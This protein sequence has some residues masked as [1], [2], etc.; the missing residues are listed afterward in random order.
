MR[1]DLCFFGLKLSPFQVFELELEDVTGLLFCK[2][3]PGDL[4]N[5]HS[6]HECLQFKVLAVESMEVLNAPRI[7][8]VRNGE[9]Y[10]NSAACDVG[11]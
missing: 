3:W 6:T 5:K 11:R 9:L 1:D 4:E 2:P 8:S 7:D 10:Y